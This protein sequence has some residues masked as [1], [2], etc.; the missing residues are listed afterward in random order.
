MRGMK[1]N[2][3]ELTLDCLNYLH[4]YHYYIILVVINVI[5]CAPELVNFNIRDTIILYRSCI[6]NCIYKEIF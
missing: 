5:F 1:R 2:Q 6:Y 4:H 3:S